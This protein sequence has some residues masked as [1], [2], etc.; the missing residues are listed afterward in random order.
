R[1]VRPGVWIEESAVVDRGARVVGPAYVGPHVRVSASSVIT[2]SSNLEHGSQ[3]DYG[4]IVED[5]SVLAGTYLG[6][7]LDVTHAVV[8]GSSLADLRRNH[9]IEISDAKLL[10]T[11]SPDRGSLRSLRHLLASGSRRTISRNARW[12]A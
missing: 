11:A 2:R 8:R 10:A 6:V 3:V 7:G 1:E 5:A 9:Q 12:S 4:T